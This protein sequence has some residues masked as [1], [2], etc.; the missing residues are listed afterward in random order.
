L[1]TAT[2]M[3]VRSASSA[4]ELAEMAELSVDIDDQPL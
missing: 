2:S 1:D 4:E 3:R